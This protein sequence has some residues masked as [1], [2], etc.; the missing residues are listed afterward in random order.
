MP[1]DPP[2]ETPDDRPP[3][4]VR[5]PAGDDRFVRRARVLALASF[6]VLAIRHDHIAED[7]F[8]TW[9]YGRNLAL[10]RG[11]VFN[12]GESPPV[13]G[14][15]DFLWVLYGALWQ[16]LGLAPWWPVAITTLGCAVATLFLVER[17]AR[18][19]LQLGPEATAAA[20]LLTATAPPFTRWATSGLEP[21]A[22]TATFAWAAWWTAFGRGRRDGWRAGWTLLA[23]SLLRTEGIGWTPILVALAAGLRHLEG[24]RDPAL[25]LRAAALPAVGWTAWFAWK[26]A[27]HGSM[28]SNVALAKVAFGPLTVERGLAYVVLAVVVLVWPLLTAPGLVHLGGRQ[29]WRALWL[30][31]LVL[32]LP[33][34]S[35]AVGGDYMPWFRFLVPGVP[36]AALAAAGAVAALASGGRGAAVALT[37]VAVAC[38]LAASFDLVPWPKAWLRPLDHMSKPSIRDSAVFLKGRFRSPS[39]ERRLVDE[40]HVASAFLG[41]GDSLVTGAIGNIGY[42]NP[43]LA[44]HDL[45]GLVDREVARRPTEPEADKRPGHE[46]CT[47]PAFFYDRKPTVLVLDVIEPPRVAEKA[48]R[49]VEGWRGLDRANRYAPQVVAVRNDRVE[50]GVAFGLALRR[51]PAGADRK[52]QYAAFE[53]ALDAI[54]AGRIPPEIRA[55]S[56]LGSVPP[57]SAGPIRGLLQGR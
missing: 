16:L 7:A 53:A 4:D 19:P 31:A 11:L 52:A 34:L 30:A 23:L 20:M 10:G 27:Y 36:F 42:F 1:E 46:K 39:P 41:A 13:E 9:R 49:R 55:E 54:D 14:Y 40:A 38:N 45:C 44:L 57:S 8:I 26:T 24:R 17:L 35:V 21:M 47:G 32:A 33:G 12:P 48:R 50:G 15:S 2:I 56:P 25:L 5:D 6:A 3:G 43:D 29:R 37:A 18:G 28:V 22:V 51:V